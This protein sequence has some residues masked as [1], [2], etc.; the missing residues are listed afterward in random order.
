MAS[1]K[2]AG[3]SLVYVLPVEDG[4]L[5]SGFLHRCM[6]AGGNTRVKD[7]ATTLVERQTIQPPWSIP[8]NLNQLNEQLWPVF[9]SAEELMLKHTC[10]PAYLPFAADGAAERVLKHVY[11]GGDAL[12]LAPTLGLAG[13]F[14]VTK[15]EMAVC[16]S[17]VKADKLRLGFAYFHREHALGGVTYCGHHGLP[18]MVGCGTCRFSQT[19]SRVARRPGLTC[20]CGKPLKLMSPSVSGE[21]GEVLARMA[22][23]GSTLLDGALAGCDAKRIGRY[24]QWQAIQAGFDNGTRVSS[25]KVT[26]LLQKNYSEEVLAALNASIGKRDWV[27]FCIGRGEA[28]PVL[29]RNLL[30]FDLFARKVPSTEDLALAEESFQRRMTAR[31][32]TR[33]KSESGNSLDKAVDREALL[34]YLAEHPDATRQSILEALGKLP[35]RIRERDADWYEQVMPASRRGGKP[36]SAE[37]AAEALASADDRAVAHIRRRREELLSADSATPKMITKTALLKGLPQGNALS[38]TRLESMPKTRAALAESIETK[39]EFQLRFAA[40][41]LSQPGDL[42]ELFTLAMRST[43]LTFEEVDDVCTARL[44]KHYGTS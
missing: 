8:S 7:L 40:L 5:I 39:K 25:R 15:P 44:K 37:E 10:L 13:N 24:Y 27:A 17:C 9:Q 19:K 6:W 21:D 32:W 42:D 16:P 28:P 26:D 1:S 41:I 36:N 4:E 33:T 23:Y 22:R 11:E 20:E 18:L 34:Q 3:T 2:Y 14:I 29:G 12:K 43:G 38:A 35:M 30:L 31:N